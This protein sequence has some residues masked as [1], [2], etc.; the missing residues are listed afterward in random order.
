MKPIYGAIGVLS[1][2]VVAAVAF[3]AWPR[4]ATAVDEKQALDRFR[5]TTS[6]SD[7]S[8]E[9]SGGGPASGADEPPTPPVGVYTYSSVGQEEVKLGPF[10]TETRTF[11]ATLTASVVDRRPNNRNERCFDFELTLI[12][13]HVETT[14]FCARWADGAGPDN[15][16]TDRSSLTTVAH[17]KRLRMGPATPTA[18]L[19]CGPPLQV[20]ADTPMNDVACS[21]TLSGGPRE[22]TA[23]MRGSVSIPEPAT[24]EVAGNAVAV[25]MVKTDYIASGKVAGTWSE[26]MW[27]SNDDWLPVRIVRQVNLSGPASIKETSELN[28]TS[29]EPSK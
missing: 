25:Q 10:P 19:V 27:L 18:T 7:G 9:R 24:L 29:L 22:V 1:I 13:E 20:S 21:L 8:V 11:P 17:S 16:G 23:E 4:G 14:G 15:V 28:L 2:V 5:A 12:A 3:I 6:T 26:T